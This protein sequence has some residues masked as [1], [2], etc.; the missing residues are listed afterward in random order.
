MKPHNT[1]YSRFYFIFHRDHKVDFSPFRELGFG[2]VDEGPCW[3]FCADKFSR[4]PV[5]IGYRHEN[6]DGIYL[7]ILKSGEHICF[8]SD[9]MS[10]V[11]AF[12]ME[13]DQWAIVASDLRLMIDIGKILHLDLKID[14][15]SASEFLITGYV[16]TQQKTLIQDVHLL[17]P[18]HRLEL[19]VLKGN[20]K[21]EN[22]G[23]KIK[24]SS[25][26]LDKKDAP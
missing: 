3:L 8:E 14:L 15:T 1:R 5:D 20:V 4:L 6:G 7:Q 19:N 17:P 25:H 24:Y 23:E 12:W 10:G 21:I 22:F 18:S 13:K 2:K 16:F 9:E 11:P 26:R